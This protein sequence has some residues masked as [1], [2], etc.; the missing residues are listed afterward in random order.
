MKTAPEAKSTF[1]EKLLL[2]IHSGKRNTA[3]QRNL[4]SKENFVSGNQDYFFTL[5][6]VSPVKAETPRNTAGTQARCQ[7]RVEKYD[8]RKFD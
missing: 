1:A 2:S 4:N 7:S 8:C 6:Y 5:L 3:P